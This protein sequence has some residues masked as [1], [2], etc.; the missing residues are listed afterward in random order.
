[1]DWIPN[2]LEYSHWWILGVLFIILEV[3]LPG[4]VFLWLGVAAGVVGGLLVFFPDLGWKTQVLWFSALSLISVVG[5]H[6]F[7]KQHPTETD[8]PTLN[9]RGSQY[10]GRVFT[11]EEP[12]ID[13]V[14]R[15]R[16]DDTGWKIAGPDIPAGHKVRVTAVDSTLLRIE[17]LDPPA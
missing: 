15:I 5:W 17:P 1:M 13:G 7:L 2:P 3:L 11:L 6:G 14:G 10:I 12:I 4:V 16:V 9:R 8:R